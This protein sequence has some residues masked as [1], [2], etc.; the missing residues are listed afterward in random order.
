M[1]AALRPGLREPFPERFAWWDRIALKPPVTDLHY[2]LLLY[3]C[4]KKRADI[5]AEDAVCDP[6]MGRGRIPAGRHRQSMDYCCLLVFG[7]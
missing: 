3:D 5:V 2:Y 7:I 4:M 6:W 1:G